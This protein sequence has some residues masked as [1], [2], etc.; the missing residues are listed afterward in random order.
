MNAIG[1]RPDTDRVLAAELAGGALLDLGP[2][3]WT[4]VSPPLFFGDDRD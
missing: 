1:R 3:P 2:Y 4:W